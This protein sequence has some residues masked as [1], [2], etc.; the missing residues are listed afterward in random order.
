MPGSAP[1]YAAI[2]SSGDG[3]ENTPHGVRPLHLPW[4][5]AAGRW[6]ALGF[7]FPGIGAEAPFPS[8]RVAL[9]ARAEMVHISRTDRRHRQ[10]DQ[11]IRCAELAVDDGAVADIGAEAQ[12]ALD[13]WR[14]KLQRPPPA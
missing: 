1:A 8:R 6:V 13:Q 7:S 14:Q 10:D 5:G 12:I 2:M 4:S 3:F 9:G 11:H